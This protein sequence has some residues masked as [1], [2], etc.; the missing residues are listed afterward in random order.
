MFHTDIDKIIY[1]GKYRYI[2]KFTYSKGLEIKTYKCEPYEI[3]YLG[4]NKTLVLFAFDLKENTIKSFK[5]LKIHQVVITDK[6]FE[7]RYPFRTGFL[8]PP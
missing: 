3:K 4:K 6:R 1:A 2:I 7:L 5:L 8:D